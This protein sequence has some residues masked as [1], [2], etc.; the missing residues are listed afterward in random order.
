M[1]Q[2]FKNISLDRDGYLKCR[3]QKIKTQYCP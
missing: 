1:G 2:D 3:K